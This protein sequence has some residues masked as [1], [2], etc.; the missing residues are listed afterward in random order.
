VEASG[1]WSSFSALRSLLC[2]LLP[3]WYL[4]WYVTQKVVM[5]RVSE[6]AEDAED[7]VLGPY[8]KDLGA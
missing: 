8:K 6:D 5:D 2:L 3:L 1:G 7:G 4:Q